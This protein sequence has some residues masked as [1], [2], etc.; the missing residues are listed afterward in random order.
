MIHIIHNRL[1]TTLRLLLSGAAIFVFAGCTATDVSNQPRTAMEQLLFSTA[2]DNA[3]E[4]VDIPEV[5]DETVFVDGRYLDAYD[6]QYMLGSIRSLLSRNGALLQYNREDADIIV[7]PRS[8]ALG[9]DESESLLGLPSVPIVLPAVGTFETPDL[10]LYKSTK[11]DSVAKIG[12]LAY[13]QDGSHLFSRDDLVGKSHLHQYKVLL[14]INVNF[15]N[16]PA[17]KDY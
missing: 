10:S 17:R 11:E 14:L 6:E 3:L 8:G 12:L 16:I 1:P 7:E 5:R 9:I 4:A 13:R 2:T 15:T